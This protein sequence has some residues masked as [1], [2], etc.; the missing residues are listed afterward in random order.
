MGQEVSLQNNVWDI[1]LPFQNP[2]VLDQD[3]LK[4]ERC[5]SGSAQ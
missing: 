4:E 5:L 3:G 1:L 2:Q